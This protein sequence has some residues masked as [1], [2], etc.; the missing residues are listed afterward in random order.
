MRAW[1]ERAL[2]RSVLTEEAR[3][4]LLGRG[5]TAE[6]I[7]DWKIKCFDIPDEPC[8]YVPLHKH[9]GQF[10]ERVEGK[11]IYPLY[12]PRGKLLGFDSRS[13]DQKD[14]LRF[15]MDDAHWNPTWVGMPAGMGSSRFWKP[16]ATP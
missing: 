14:N 4:Y 9:Y 10:F 15:L 16:T 5:A 6:I 3:Y 7:K 13:V 1:L 8:P 12:S 2:E 11:V